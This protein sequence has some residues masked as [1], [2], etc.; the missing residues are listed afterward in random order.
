[1]D[2][3]RRK[4]WIENEPGRRRRRA[5]GIAWPYS[6][7]DRRTSARQLL[8]ACDASGNPDLA[9][10]V[11]IAL[12]SGARQA[13]IMTLRWPMLDLDRECAFL[14]TT[15]NGEPRVMPLPGDITAS[16]APAP[17]CAT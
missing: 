5:A 15:K 13:E 9:L 10:V 17:R 6:L 8:E 7:A 4:K 1:M 11:R 14:P 16:C 2:Y 3:A 12:A